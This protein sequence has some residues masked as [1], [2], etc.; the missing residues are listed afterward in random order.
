M[1]HRGAQQASARAAASRAL[2]DVFDVLIDA[3]R[4]LLR[5]WPVCLT[6]ALLGSAWRGAMLWAAVAVSDWNGIAG[7]SLL[8]LAPLGFL[9]PFVIMLRRFQPD[10]PQLAAASAVSAPDDPTTRRERRLIDVATSVLVPF[11]AVYVSYGFLSDDIASFVNEA[12]SDELGQAVENIFGGAS[13][14][15]DWHRVFVPHWQVLAMIIALAW[16]VR[17]LLGKAE[18]RWS[19]IG[20]AV[21]GALVE[22]YWTSNA[23]TYIEKGKEQAA[24]WL[25]T[26][27][28]VDSARDRYHDVV[29]GL[30]DLAHPVDTVIG[31][32][33]GIL[34]SFDAVVVVPLAWITVAAV[35]VGHTLAPPPPI[36]HPVLDRTRSWPRPIRALLSGIGQV[37][38]DVRSRFSGLVNGLRL[39]GRAGLLPMLIFALAFLLA[40]RAPYAVS[41]VWRLISGP[42]PTATFLAFSPIEVAVGEALQ[43]VVLAALLAAAVDRL[44]LPGSSAAVSPDAPT[45]SHSSEAATTA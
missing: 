4:L 28:A 32:L 20:I 15:V 43:W 2:R 17:F 11:L 44:M 18:Q 26:R 24:T 6:L 10:L 27:V 5:H 9:V 37:F 40:L 30:G 29:A 41:W 36:R 13:N 33:W 31:W 38:D 12:G 34:G 8:I 42:E 19:W 21:L 22:T 23:A 14:D 25:D 3:G 35:V 1:P 45:P 16:I 7:R 39:L